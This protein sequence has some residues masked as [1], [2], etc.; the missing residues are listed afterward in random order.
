MSE[1]GQNQLVIVDREIDLHSVE[2]VP[3]DTFPNPPENSRASI[4]GTLP[5]FQHLLLWYGIITRYNVI[6]KSLEII[7]PGLVSTPD[8]TDSVSLTVIISLAL[9]N[10]MPTGQIPSY[11]QATGDANPYNPAAEWILSQPWDGQDRLEEFCDTLVEQEDFPKKLKI[12]LIYRWLISIVAAAL[13]SC[14]FHAR[15]VLTLVGPQSLGKT[16]W[17]ANLIPAGNGLREKL[18]KLDHHLDAGSKDS[19]LAAISFLIVEIGELDSSFKR[20][21]ARLKGFI[22][23]GHDLVR[24]PYARVASEY[25]RRTVFCASVNDH[26][27]LVDSTGNSR[28]WTIPVQK[29]NYQHSINMQQLFAQIAV[30]YR[31]GVQWWLSQEEEKQLEETNKV[32]RSISAIYERILDVVDLERVDEEDWPRMTATEVLREIEIDDP[33]TGQSK[34]CNAILREL[35]GPPKRI[36]GYNYWKIPVKKKQ[37]FPGL[38]DNIY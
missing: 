19:I 14:G 25:P 3:L 38:P 35:L 15:G 1:S 31:N 13:M 22:T 10:R 33:K 16:T 36:K 5:N 20:D 27:F 21:V 26:N 34:E 30:D 6:K 28:W 17:F 37:S 11:V 7:V 8:N 18:V 23:S 2:K 32:H 12:T 24:P 4:P 9:L 29:I